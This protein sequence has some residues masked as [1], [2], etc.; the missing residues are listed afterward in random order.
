MKNSTPTKE[1]KKGSPTLHAIGFA[2][3]ISIEAYI[4]NK[5]NGEEGFTYGYKKYFRE[6]DDS[7][8]D[9]KDGNFVGYTSRRIPNTDNEKMSV[10]NGSE[11]T[12]ILM[13]RY[14]P[15]NE[16]T[17]ETRKE[18]LRFLSN[19]LKDK[20]FSEYP[21]KD[22]ETSDRTNVD[23]FAS[24]DEYFLDDKIK[25]ILIQDVEEETLNPDFFEKFNAFA[26]KVWKYKHTSAWAKNMLGYPKND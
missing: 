2:G 4:Y 5:P 8:D 23:N 13:T 26:S 6:D 12:R 9:L 18:G 21:P 3:G 14:D 16:S 10:S 20:R 7:S 24:L 11:Y 22:I 17:P 15:S 19:F 1:K 25:E